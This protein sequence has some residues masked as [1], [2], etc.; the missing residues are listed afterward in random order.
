MGVDVIQFPKPH[1]ENQYGVVFIDYL[2]E[3]PEVFALSD[4]TTLTI[5]K[6]FVKQTVCQHGVPAQL[7]PDRGAAFL[8]HLPMEIGELLGVQKLNTTAYHLQTDG[9]AEHFNRSLTDMLAKRVE[10]SVRN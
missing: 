6:L 3:W 4:Q 2:T 10:Q 1:T 9:L 7:L 8:S 5:A